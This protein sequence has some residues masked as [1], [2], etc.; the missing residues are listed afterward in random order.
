MSSV[1]TYIDVNS[2]LCLGI[3]GFLNILL[4]WLV[5]TRTPKEMR[6]Y[7]IIVGYS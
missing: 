3:G 5:C 1:R 2:K 6:P 7:S 4:G